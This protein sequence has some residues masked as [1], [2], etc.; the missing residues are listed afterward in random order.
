[1]KF[2]SLL[3][4]HDGPLRFY[5][6]G[7]KII[8]DN[9]LDLNLRY[10]FLAK[11]VTFMYRGRYTNIEMPENKIIPNINTII[12]P[13]FNHPAKLYNYF[14]ACKKIKLQLRNFDCLIIRLPSSLGSV[15]LR[16]ARKYKIPYIV[17]VVACPWDVLFNYSFVGKI[18][19]P[20]AY[21]KMK[22]NIKVSEYVI[23]V[24]QNFLQKRYPTIGKSVNISN[25]YLK[26]VD[27]RNVLEKSKL[28]TKKNKN[29]QIIFCTL[30]ALNV[31]YK[32]H[33]TVLKAL[34]EIKMHGYNFQ[35]I[36]AG[37]GDNIFIKKQISKY[38]LNENVQI[39]GFLYSEQ[40]NEIL[41]RTDIYI[42]PS[43]TEGLPRA[44]IEAMSK[45]CVCLGTNVGGIPELL[46]KEFLFEAGNNHELAEMIQNV[47][48]NY[49]MGEISLT[50]YYQA[51]NYNID[52]LNSKRIEFYNQFLTNNL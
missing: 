13:T 10:S 9:I 12:I 35:Y 24:T 31:P 27:E 25:V 7:Q 26:N 15:A 49:N 19:A 47:V 22:R 8:T 5:S 39:N 28:F 6:N 30:A 2:N 38:D 52:N 33:D 50:N 34:K 51:L 40:V 21:F 36:I 1:M 46:N 29:N 41:N 3:Y 14:S 45:G 16:Y 23:Y 42:Q 48:E 11:D 18:Y 43:K 32:G 4:V 17:E 20:F 44:M 37:S